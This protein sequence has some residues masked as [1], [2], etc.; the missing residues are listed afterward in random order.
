M[1]AEHVTV[2]DTDMALIDFFASLLV[3]IIIIINKKNVSQIFPW[4]LKITHKT[5]APYAAAIN[6]VKQAD[7]D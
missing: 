5:P 6:F 3:Q 7:R 1:C 4:V 2:S